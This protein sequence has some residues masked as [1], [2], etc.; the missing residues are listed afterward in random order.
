M[1][2]TAIIE[3]RARHLTDYQDERLANRY[4]E[5]VAQIGAGRRLGL[6]EA[7]P[8]AVATVYVKLL[9]YKDEYEVARLFTE[10]PSWPDCRDLRR[11]FRLAFHLSPPLLS[12]PTRIPD[13]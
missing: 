3:H 2:V 4:R 12:A 8:E 10:P 5:L 7:L 11:E 9:A 1:R 6:G 13:I